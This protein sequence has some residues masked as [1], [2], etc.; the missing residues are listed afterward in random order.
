[1][2]SDKVGFLA[3]NCMGAM[4]DTNLFRK[5]VK[6]AMEHF[7]LPEVDIPKEGEPPRKGIWASIDKAY[8]IAKGE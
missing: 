8:Q 4:P 3:D 1:M 6:A 7:D 5:R 2:V